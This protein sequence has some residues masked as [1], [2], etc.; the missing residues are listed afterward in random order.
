M[1]N[2]Y[3]IHKN[4]VLTKV[5]NLILIFL[6]FFISESVYSQYYTQHYIAP[7]PW[8]YFSDA[9]ELVVATESTTNVSVQVT[10][11]DGT[12]ITTL[13]VIKGTPAFYRFTGSPTAVGS[14]YYALNTVVNGA[15]LNISAAKPISI[16][17]RNVASDALMPTSTSDA[18]FIKGNASL[19]SFGSTGVGV[20]FRVGYYRDTDLGNFGGLGF[21]RPVYSVMA[22]NNNTSLSING[23]T[24]VTLNAGQSYLFEAAMGS[25]VETS[26]P[27][28]INTSAKID[29]PAGCGDG[30]L[31]QVPPISVLGTDYIVVRGQGN[32]TAEQTTVV[33][34]EPNTL[35]TI[36]QFTE[37]GALSGTTFQTLA[38]AGS[39]FTYNHGTNANFSASRIVGDKKVVVYSGTAIN[40][41]VDITSIAPV[42]Q[43]GGS[44]FVETYKFRAY[45]TNTNLPYFGNILLNSAT[46][47]VRVNGVNIETIA[48]TRRQLGSTGWYLIDFTNVQI[49]SPNSIT[50]ESLSKMTVGLVQQGGG[51]SM[52]AI[53]SSYTEIPENPTQ[54]PNTGSGCATS[55]T[56]STTPGFGPYQWFLNGNPISGANSNTYTT[57]TTGSYS[58]SSTL[59]CGAA[60]Q[61]APVPVTICADVS[62]TKTVDIDSPCVDSTVNFTITAT[63]NGPSNATGVSVLDLLPTGYAFVLATTSTGTYTSS[64]GNWAIGSLNNLQ[65]AT[66]V[67]TAR[68]NATGNYTNDATISS[69]NDSDTSN[70]TANRST[71]PNQLPAAATLTSNNPICSGAD[72]IFTIT[73]TAGNT[74]NYTGAASGTATIGA[75]GTVNVT[76]TAVTSNTILNLTNVSNGTC[77]RPL[78]ATTTVN[79]NAQNTI[80]A[81]SNRTTC[82]NT[83]ITNINLATTGATGATFS[84]LP[85]GIT[86]SWAAN[87]VIISGTPTASGTFNY[88]V[89]TTGGCP[90]ATTTGTITVSPI[91]SNNNLIYTNGSSAQISVTVNEGASAVLNAPA[92]TYFSSV[93]FASYG[94]P[95]GTA[96]N[97]SI[98]SACHSPT[99]QS[100]VERLLGNS[101]GTIPARNTVFGD[102]CGGVVKRLSIVTTYVEPICSGSIFTING[103]APA[104]GNGTY[105]YLWESSSVSAISGF[106]AAAGTNSNISYSSGGIT[107]NTWFRRTVISGSCSSTST[108]VLVRVAPNNTASSAS[109][110]PTLCINTA[111]TNITHTTIGAT[112][113][114]TATGLPTG[115]TAT[116]ASNT[117]TISGTPTASGAFDYSI[118]L[119]GGCG[120]VNATG[121]II[122]TPNNT[123]SAASSTPTLCINT[124]LTNITHT[125]TGATGIGTA[126]GLPTGVTAAFASNSI[127]ISGTPTASGTFDYSI[128]LTGGCGSVN[129]AGTITVT[130]NN[131]VSAASSTPTLC[132]NTPLTNITHTTTGATGIG[133]ATGLPGGVTATF[134]SN[135]ITISG[136]PTAS[137]IFNYSIPLTGGC[138]E[139]TATG[140]ISIYAPTVSLSG[141]TSV[142]ENSGSS[143]LLT[144]TLSTATISDVIITIS[145]SGTATSGSDHTA[146]SLTITIPSGSTSGTV[147][148]T[149]IDD[150]INEGPETVIANIDNVTGGCATELGTQSATVTITDND[151]VPTVA[152]ITPASATEGSPVVFEFSLSNPSAEDTTYTFTFTNG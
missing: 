83:A 34:T 55:A 30:T 85:A 99:S 69:S 121:R 70:N 106:A 65:S 134:A 77:S 152:T 58:V 112:G 141:T 140:T 62:I 17:I 118:P 102:P 111:L 107:Q 22:I 143:A 19:T 87:V 67:I 13:S 5:K 98:N 45:D 109:S 117:I 53:F 81:G 28:V 18:N 88:T 14:E 132:I 39:F 12:V 37:T 104:G 71:T 150:N 91:L 16:N 72:A 145:Y 44:N 42:S 108:V 9:N 96:P 122:V 49:S 82:V 35:L 46:E 21:R 31:D 26:G 89:T 84:G 146:S 144:A 1:E 115:V 32:T 47:I 20:S 113:I 38:T 95:T 79:V 59:S 41:E 73:G 2:H 36:Q 119:T 11:S 24:T 142:A 68:V 101:T 97:F 66:M 128:P 123:V 86:G 136:A 10:R 135:T 75:G 100:V 129:A 52:A 54:V 151:A 147:T 7:A 116:F 29:T 131:T 139:V 4:N 90:P 78:T 130:P 93:N 127:T 103:S 60:A 149:P 133:T 23:V 125:T 3:F 40:C 57:T 50:I 61:S 137:G 63:N 51:F 126:T 76:I 92:G 120:S 138:G 15:G 74:V 6:L 80:A 33:A 124:A 94:T 110:S 105:N 114:G 43:C 8:R 148:I 25:L 27:A 48:G 56:L 64:N